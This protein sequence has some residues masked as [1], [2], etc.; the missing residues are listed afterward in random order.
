MMS[1]TTH[2]LDEE[3]EL[4]LHF[5]LNEDCESA[6][7]MPD[8]SSLHELVSASAVDRRSASWVRQD[9]TSTAS[10]SSVGNKSRPP[11]KERLV[12][13]RPGRPPLAS[14]YNEEQ[15]MPSSIFHGKNQ[16]GLVRGQAGTNK[17]SVSLPV[18]QQLEQQLSQALLDAE[19]CGCS[20][21]A[22][23]A[24]QLC[25][26]YN[27]QALKYMESSPGQLP[28]A[29]ELLQKALILAEVGGVLHSIASEV[30]HRKVL[31]ATCN[32]LGCYY[33]RKAK[34]EAALHY[35][36]RAA[37]LSRL[38]GEPLSG[39]QLQAAVED[40]EAAAQTLLNLCAV[41]S[42]LGRHEEAL[43]QAERAA[44]LLCSSHGLEL[45]TLEEASTAPRLPYLKSIPT[46]TTSASKPR[47]A[48]SLSSRYSSLSG[49]DLLPKLAKSK[50]AT[51]Y[52]PSLSRQ[53]SSYASSSSLG[54]SGEVSLFSCQNFQEAP[55]LGHKL[56]TLT[57]SEATMLSVSLYNRAVEIEHL[58]RLKAALP[59]YAS[60]AWLSNRV[61]G[62]T[63]SLAKKLN[64]SLQA[65]QKRLHDERRRAQRPNLGA[66]APEMMSSPGL[67]GRGTQSK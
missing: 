6:E 58:G 61:M 15:R 32:A 24:E 67:T 30:D 25:K 20:L 16:T 17:N 59:A 44:Q 55:E 46:L 3:E 21:P 66:S 34:A 65:F 38:Q 53:S 18:I 36:Q 14:R 31:S 29:F 12:G 8:P 41:L 35:L 23:V 47:S 40:C 50:S 22:G 49:G 7:A 63:S 9:R 27:M 5:V 26:S 43:Q 56:K 37:T 13:V 19:Q 60:A 33:K 45:S 4:F 51:I 2:S 42:T 39:G 52:S 11:L 57:P 64:S 10:G 48:S 1:R 54:S 28:D 62:R